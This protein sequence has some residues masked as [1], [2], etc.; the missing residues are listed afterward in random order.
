MIGDGGGGMDEEGEEFGEGW[1]GADA[2]L[3]EDDSRPT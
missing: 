2:T 1:E 3:W